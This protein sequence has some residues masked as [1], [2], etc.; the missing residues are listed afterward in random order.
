MNKATVTLGVMLC[1][2]GAGPIWGQVFNDLEDVKDREIEWQ[3]FFVSGL[4]SGE[5][6]LRTNDGFNDIE[7]KTDD[8]WLIGVRASGENEYLGAEVTLAG[9]FADLDFEA[10]PFAT[11]PSGSDARTFLLSFNGLFYPTGNELLEGRIRPYLTVGPEMAVID[12]DY[13]KVSGETVFG[14]NVGLGIKFLLGDSGNVILRADWRWHNFFYSTGGLKS[15][16]YHQEL[17][18]GIGIRF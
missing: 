16:I 10:D 1:L 7:V 18:A 4:F 6:L 5:T 13:S 2:A 8:G 11:V 17:T 15:R 9:V 12:T 3:A 14:A